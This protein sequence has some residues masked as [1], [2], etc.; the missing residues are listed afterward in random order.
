MG[1]LDQITTGKQHKPRRTLVYG[2]HGIGKSTFGAMADK[3]IILPTEDGTGEIDCHR[4]PLLESYEQVMQAIAELYKSD[5][6]YGTAVV[7]SAD[8][9]EKLIWRDVCQKRSV[10][11][12]EDVGYGKGY[13]FALAQWGHFL[14]G[15]DALRNDRGMAVI[16]IAHANIEKFNNPETDPY[17]RYSPRLHKQASAVVQEWCD[18]V[19]FATYKVHTKE[20]DEGFN[21]QRTRG[22][23]T[24]ERILRCVERPA[25]VAKN[26]LDMPDEIPLDWREY[27]NYFASA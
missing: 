4:F 13:I 10:E 8:W 22:I 25:H 12:I 18:E 15:L 16:I 1:L 26:R 21:K 5:H 24:G 14:D 2:T 19:L 11:S 17:D 3:P 7:D 20:K 6:A 27:A 23:G 9:L